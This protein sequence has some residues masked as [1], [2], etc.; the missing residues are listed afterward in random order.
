MS[1]PISGPLIC[2]YCGHRTAADVL[3]AGQSSICPKCNCTFQAPDQQ[4]TRADQERAAVITCGI[5]LLTAA[6]VAGL[7]WFLRKL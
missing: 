7:L 2:P 4:T 6:A 5:F 1:V 3:Y